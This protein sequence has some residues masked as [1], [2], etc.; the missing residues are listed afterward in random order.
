MYDVARILLSPRLIFREAAFMKA[1]PSDDQPKRQAARRPR[2]RRPKHPGLAALE[3][4]ERN[5]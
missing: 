4:R 3:A 1:R 2:N 5:I